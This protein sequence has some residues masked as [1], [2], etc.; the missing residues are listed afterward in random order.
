MLL[1]NDQ[2][3]D[4]LQDASSSEAGPEIATEPGGG[5]SHRTGQGSEYYL[6]G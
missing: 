1:A 6:R 2:A 5:G 3:I 4:V